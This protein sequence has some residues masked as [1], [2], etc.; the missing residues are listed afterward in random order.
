MRPRRP[1]AAPLYVIE[2]RPADNA[3]VVGPRNALRR[4][5]VEAMDCAWVSGSPPP[6]G[7]AVLVQLRA[8]GHQHQ[9]A[10]DDA[11]AGIMRLRFRSAVEQVSPGQAVVLYDGD[12]VLGGGTVRRAA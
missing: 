4:C 8:H 1:D 11:G 5:T 12:E 3:V 9:A 7:A 2:V 6:H 10:V